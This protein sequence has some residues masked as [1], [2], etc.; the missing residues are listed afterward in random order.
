M[1]LAKV[2]ILKCVNPYMNENAI[3]YQKEGADVSRPLSFREEEI[4][5]LV[6]SW[7]QS[8]LP[9]SDAEHALLETLQEEIAFQKA[10][11]SVSES[12]RAVLE[13][14]LGKFQVVSYT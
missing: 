14:Y 2:K 8:Y 11:K 3:N 9:L 4:N 12:F 1:L 13:Q 10:L 7:P 6:A 5:R